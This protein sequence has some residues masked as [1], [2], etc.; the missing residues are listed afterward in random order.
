MR[1]KKFIVNKYQNADQWKNKKFW[2]SFIQS[3]IHIFT[4]KQ[5]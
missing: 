1:V 3:F 4:D 5:K 2:K